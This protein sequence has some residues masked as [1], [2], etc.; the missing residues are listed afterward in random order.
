M[1]ASEQTNE[2]GQGSDFENLNKLDLETKVLKLE[3]RS[4]LQDDVNAKRSLL[5]S[6]LGLD[7]VDLIRD[8]HYPKIRY[9]LRQLDLGFFFD[10]KHTHVRCAYTNLEPSRSDIMRNG[11]R[12]GLLIELPTT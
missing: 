1:S 3:A 5:V 12:G 10:M 2:Q 9:F 11:W 8:N 4:R 6:N 7:N